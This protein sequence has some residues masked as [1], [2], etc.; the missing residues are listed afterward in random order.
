MLI[1]PYAFL[2]FSGERAP[3]IIPRATRSSV[4]SVEK[5]QKNRT[6]K[7]SSLSSP[8]DQTS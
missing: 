2:S 1:I 7:F 4:M 8:M 3:S 5:G 6:A